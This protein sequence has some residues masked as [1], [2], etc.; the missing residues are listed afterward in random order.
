MLLGLTNRNRRFATKKAANKKQN[1]GRNFPVTD[2]L[3]LAYLGKIRHSGEPLTPILA[4]SGCPELSK[5]SRC[6]NCTFHETIICYTLV[7]H[8]LTPKKFPGTFFDHL[9]C[10]QQ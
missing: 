3:S 6:T 7:R 2:P 8:P 9:E 10:Y 5:P 1:T 4:M